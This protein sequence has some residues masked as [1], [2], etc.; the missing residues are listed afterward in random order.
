MIEF[1]PSAIADAI[2]AEVVGEG[3]PGFPARAS[4]DSRSVESGDLFFGLPGE[5]ADGG[6][7]ATRALEDGAW[8]AVIGSERAGEVAE[9]GQGWVFASDDPLS[10]LQR[11]ATAWR[12]ELAVP[13]L[14]ITG[15][16]GKTSVKDI[17][18]AILPG[19]VHANE[20]NLNT[21]IGLPLTVL[22]APRETDL[23]VLEMAM[24]GFGQIALLAEVAEPEVGVITC[25]G[26]V[27]VELV[28]SVEGVARAKAE[29]I[30]GLPPDGTLVAPAEPGA[31]GPHLERAPRLI[32]FGDG[33]DVRAE[34]VEVAEGGLSATVVT[35]AG[36]EP[37]RFPF[38][39]RHNLTNALA[40][41]AAG[42][43]LGFGPGEMSAGAGRIRLSDLRGE[44]IRLPGGAVLI[45]DC[46]NANPVSMEAAIANLAAEQAGR[47]VAVL[48]LMGE[49]GERSG[50]Y[51]AEVGEFARR[52]GVDLVIGVGPEAAGYEPDL[53]VDDAAG[54]AAELRDLDEEGTVV[55]VKGSRSAGLEAVAET[56]VG[57]GD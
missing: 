31:L 8:G 47:R 50:A 41:I 26:P 52:A 22:S 24:R 54:A 6:E 48:G 37:F 42:L 45:N 12:R 19:R 43:A 55:L 32:T 18:R 36:E 4:I 39:E 51:H 28:G 56:V 23:M 30:D 2:G 25:V 17:A 33:G 10:A 20:Q 40:A 3:G 34:A 35:P 57:R 46:Y 53:L 15:S 1:E 7:F 5:R 49:L 44:R 13:V 27:H 21:E 29:L 16:V 38:T 11:L 9:T 14:G